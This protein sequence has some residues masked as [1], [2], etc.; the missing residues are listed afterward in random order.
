[1]ACLNFNAGGRVSEHSS[2]NMKKVKARVS[3][4]AP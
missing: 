1:M 3:V 2:V 4:M